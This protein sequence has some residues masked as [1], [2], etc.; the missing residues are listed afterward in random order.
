MNPIILFILLGATFALLSFLFGLTGIVIGAI[1]SSYL[2]KNNYERWCEISTIST[3]IGDIGPGARDSGKTLKY[4]NNNDDLEDP[5]I[6]RY[7]KYIKI[8]IKGV[9]IFI[10]ISLM[11]FGIT[12]LLIYLSKH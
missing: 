11:S 9:G 3:A 2:K 5:N 1:F 10:L 7:K 4:I 8:S 6:F 12:I